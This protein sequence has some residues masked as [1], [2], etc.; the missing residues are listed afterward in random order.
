[1]LH[2]NQ[3]RGTPTAA[4]SSNWPFRFRSGKISAACRSAQKIFNVEC[5]AWLIDWVVEGTSKKYSCGSITQL[6]NGCKNRKGIPGTDE[7]FLELW[8]QQDNAEWSGSDLMWSEWDL[9]YCL[10]SL[11]ALMLILSIKASSFSFNDS[12][13]SLLMNTCSSSMT[14]KINGIIHGTCC[15][16]KN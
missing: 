4:P 11:A 1:M 8:S 7:W 14:C 2:E 3:L 10:S 12:T 13:T 5:I 9:L 15:V 6:G 16:K